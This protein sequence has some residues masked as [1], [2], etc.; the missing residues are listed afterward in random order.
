MFTCL[1]D[2]CV[3]IILL[4]NYTEKLSHVTKIIIL[5]FCLPWPGS[6]CHHFGQAGLGAWVWE[7][8]LNK[9]LKVRIDSDKSV[10]ETFAGICDISSSHNKLAKFDITKSAWYSFISLSHCR[11]PQNYNWKAQGEP[12]V[13]PLLMVWRYFHIYILFLSFTVYCYVAYSLTFWQSFA[14]RIRE[15]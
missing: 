11:Y 3:D 13:F 14:L 1:T 10:C 9:S 4:L 7:I 5:L 2:L 12:R 15:L 6:R 8:N